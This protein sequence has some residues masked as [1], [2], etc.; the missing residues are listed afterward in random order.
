MSSQ[1][2]HGP[3][4]KYHDGFCVRKILER[5]K[6]RSTDFF[7]KAEIVR[8][9][10][11]LLEDPVID[12][13]VI[14]TPD[15]YHY[16][17]AR[18]A[19]ESGKH[20]VVE[21]PFTMTVSEA[22][23]LIGFARSEGLMLTVFHNRRWDSDFLT[24][25]NVLMS[26]VLGK[27]S[28]FESHFDRYRTDIV[29]GSWKEDRVEGTGVLYNLGSHMIDQALQL[30]GMPHE[31]FADLRIIRKGGS[32]FDYYFLYLYYKDLRVILRSSY[33]IYENSMKYLVHGT[34]GTYTKRGMDP[35]EDDLA[36]GLNPTSVGWGEESQ[37]NEATL[38]TP[39]KTTR[40]KGIAGNYMAFYNNVYAHLHHKEELA[41]LPEEASQV[42]RMIELALKSHDEKRVVPVT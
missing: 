9:Y 1:I 38:Y 27:I 12:L 14:N 23:S 7:P 33:L 2:F 29:A 36:N 39:D 22:Q 31:I 25:R 13:V 8:R 5:V 19:L 28:E 4:L 15:V 32:V 17:M 3:L 34:G 11:D 18:K 21:K 37:E 10:D 20:V 6:S 40:I 24:L 35:Q 30:F 42:I 26:G 16:D 41:V